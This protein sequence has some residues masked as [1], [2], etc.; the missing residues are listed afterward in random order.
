MLQGLDAAQLPSQRLSLNPQDAFRTISS[1]QAGL[2]IGCAGARAASS[3]T[4]LRDRKTSGWFQPQTQRLTRQL[5]HCFLFSSNSVGPTQRAVG[6][7]SVW[8]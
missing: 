1:S 5:D 8:R 6:R 4:N 3:P 7:F 2:R